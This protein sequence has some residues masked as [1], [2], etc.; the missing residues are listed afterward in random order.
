MHP[1][2]TMSDDGYGDSQIEMDIRQSL[3]LQSDAGYSDCSEALGGSEV[4]QIN[5]EE[6]SIVLLE[7]SQPEVLPESEVAPNV[8]EDTSCIL[9]E[10]SQA[11]VPP[12]SEVIII[13][14]SQ[15]DA[16]VSPPTSRRIRKKVTQPMSLTSMEAEWKRDMQRWAAP[17]LEAMADHVPGEQTCP[18]NIVSPFTGNFSEGFEAVV[19]RLLLFLLVL[20]V[21]DGSYEGQLRNYLLSWHSG[22]NSGMS[23]AAI[24]RSPLRSSWI[25]IGKAGSDACSATSRI[26]ALRTRATLRNACGTLATSFLRC[27]HAIQS[28]VDRMLSSGLAHATH[29]PPW[30]LDPKDICQR[31][32]R[33]TAA[34]LTRRTVCFLLLKTGSLISSCR[35]TSRLSPTAPRM[36]VHHIWIGLW[37][38]LTRSGMNW[39]PMPMLLVGAKCINLITSRANGLGPRSILFKY[40]Q[41]CSRILMYF[42]VLQGVSPHWAPLGDPRGALW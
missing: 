3:D 22:S 29:T 26:C 20:L 5:G 28:L 13:S 31:A 16:P 18:L 39:A 41:G 25:I 37:A 24:A 1:I 8:G 30:Q 12:Q 11:E 9:L 4:A 7:D 40:S 32:M 38:E 23:S 15:A 17:L 27:F 6:A 10:D 33:N 21:I 19:H 2:V 35:K 34:H 42:Q 14:E 36:V